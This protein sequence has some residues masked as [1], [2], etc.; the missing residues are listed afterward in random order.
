MLQPDGRYRKTRKA[1]NEPGHAH[2]LTFSCYKRLPLL[3]KD[4]TRIWFTNALDRARRKWKLDLW[5]YVIMP[6][7]AHVLLFPQEDEYDMSMILKSIKQSVARKAINHL[8]DEAPQW[9][10]NLRVPS[11]SAV[12]EYRFWEA[13]GGYDRNIIKVESAWFAV[14]YLHRNPVRRKLVADPLEWEWSS[15]RWYAGHSDVRLVMDGGPPRS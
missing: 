14:D 9:L 10:I 15:S 4:R 11:S 13:G 12:P 1:Y 6:E 2:E 3:S 7:H 8:H 5:A